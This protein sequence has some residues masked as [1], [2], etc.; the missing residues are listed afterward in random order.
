[1]PTVIDR[2]GVIRLLAEGAQLLDV[3]EPDDYAG[4]HIAGAIN[5]H[6]KKMNARGTSVLD[7]ARPVITSCH[8]FT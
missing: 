5:I 6:L 4:A 7:K 8:D 3:L 1:V 2:D